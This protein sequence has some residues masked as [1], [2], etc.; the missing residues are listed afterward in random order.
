M[1]CKYRNIFGEPKHGIHSIRLFDIAIIDA[2]LTLLL[3][4]VIAKILR[5]NIWLTFI[6]LLILSVFIH[7]IFCVETTLTKIFFGNQYFK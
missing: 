5:I 4:I 6:G 3:S 7:R 2:I 1:L